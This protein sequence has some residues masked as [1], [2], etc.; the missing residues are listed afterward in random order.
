MY[1][2]PLQTTAILMSTF[3]NVKNKISFMK[4]GFILEF[5]RTYSGLKE[6]SNQQ[7]FIPL[8]LHLT[9]KLDYNKL[10]N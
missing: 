6:R 1:I 2:E 5:E 7:P 4:F 3:L 10:N 9:T 8:Y